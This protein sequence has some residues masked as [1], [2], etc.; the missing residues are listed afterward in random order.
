MAK[1]RTVDIVEAFALPIAEENGVEL[2]DVEY[3]KE[4]QDWFLRVYIDKENGITLDDC[5]AVSEALSKKLDETDP[6]EE[7]YYL[8]VSSPGLDRELKKDKDYEKFKG[9]MIQI[10]LYEPL[11]GKKMIEGELLG[12][13]GNAVVIKV[14]ERHN[15]EIPRE[16]IGKVKLAV[17]IE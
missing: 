12:L 9:R 13:E 5:Q 4:G 6:I 16:K 3:I 17:I 15:L 1:K 7:S 11:D 2:V 14:D 8:E 10:S